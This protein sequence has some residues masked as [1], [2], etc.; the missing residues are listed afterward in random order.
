MKNLVNISLFSPKHNEVLLKL[1][2]FEL[3]FF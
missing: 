3:K 1:D 2:N